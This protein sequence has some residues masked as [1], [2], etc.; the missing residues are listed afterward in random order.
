HLNSIFDSFNG[1]MLVSIA[2]G[3]V[4]DETGTLYYVNAEH[5]W[6]VLYR[7]GRAAFIEDDAYFRKL[8]M[9]DPETPFFVRT[10]QLEP[11]D[12]LIAGSDGR[13]DLVL[14]GDDGQM[15]MCEDERLFLKIVE[16]A[17]GDLEA[18][19][20]NLLERGEFSDDLSLIRVAYHPSP[21]QIGGPEKARDRELALRQ[22]RSF[23]RQENWPASIERL[24]Q[25]DAPNGDP[26]LRREL[27]RSYSGAKDY[28]AASKTALAYM[29]SRPHDFDMLVAASRLCKKANQLD[30][31]IDQAERACL[32]NPQ[33][34]PT[35]ILLSELYARTGQY[36]RAAGFLDMAESRAPGDARVQKIR[37]YL[38][39][40][41]T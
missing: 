13:D 4:D 18:I 30:T 8:G 23:A 14:P 37:R 22:A 27:V 2:L 31:A 41:G 12:V 39:N 19:R 15:M 40:S 26:S 10:L 35:L 34:L 24:L 11:G 3:V 5:P 25:A 38:Y 6:T 36:E 28:Q 7:Q 21:R 20:G 17:D 16:Q 9:A 32:R 1:S 33:H 29:E